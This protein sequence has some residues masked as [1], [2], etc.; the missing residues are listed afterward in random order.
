[1]SLRAPVGDR[2][3]RYEIRWRKIGE[4]LDEHRVL[5]WSMKESGARQMRDAWLK[6]PDVETCW[7]IDRETGKRVP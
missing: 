5:G 3:Q 6:A 1:M 4:P 2:G 7:I